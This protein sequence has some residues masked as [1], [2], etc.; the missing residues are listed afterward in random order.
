MVY[1]LA[2]ILVLLVLWSPLAVHALGL[3]EIDTHSALNQP[4]QAEIELLSVRPDE[5]DSI[6]AK[7]ASNATFEQAGVE[8]ISALSNLRFKVEQKPNGDHYIRVYTQELIKEPFLN[9]LIEVNW[10]AGHL[11]REY[12]VLL[13]PPVLT[14]ASPPRIQTPTA[15]V[16]PAPQ[17]DA[18]TGTAQSTPDVAPPSPVAPDTTTAPTPR[19]SNAELVRVNDTLWSVTQRLR[20]NAAIS[21]QQMMLALLKANPEAFVGNNVNNLKAGQRLHVP[22]TGEITLISQDDALRE[23]KR[24]HA[25]WAG[26]KAKPAVAAR[27]DESG[28][29][30]AAHIKLVAP[31]DANASASNSTA[32]DTV[33]SIDDLQKNLALANEAAESRRQE[34]DELR[35]RLAELEKQVESMQ[36]LITLKDENLANLQNN[37]ST[38]KP[39]EAATPP[40]PQEPAPQQAAPSTEPA[41]PAKPAPVAKSATDTPAPGA[42]QALWGDL[43]SNP[44]TQAIVVAAV[45]LLLALLWVVNR[46]RQMNAD[47]LTESDFYSMNLPLG[48]THAETAAAHTAIAAPETPHTVPHDQLAEVNVYLDFEQYPQAEALLKQLIAKDPHSDELKLRLLELYSLTKNKNAFGTQAEYLHTALGGQSSP[49]WDKAVSLGVQFYPQHPLFAAAA[50]VVRGAPAPV[51][52]VA[53]EPSQ[54]MDFTLDVPTAEEKQS[55]APSDGPLTFDF[56]IASSNQTEPDTTDSIDS[57]IEFSLT[58]FEQELESLTKASVTPEPSTTELPALDF[59]LDDLTPASPSATAKKREPDISFDFDFEKEAEALADSNM[60]TLEYEPDGDT[61]PFAVG[62]EIGTKIDLAR[63][64]IDMGDDDG[65]RSI[66]EEV[67][68][69]GN[70]AQKNEA[71]ELIRQLKS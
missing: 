68:V 31:N 27:T 1:T 3:G 25:L 56:D 21:P 7:L 23:I 39:D 10:S 55:P 29:A 62:D 40:A 50:G 13:D 6:V 20:P 60:T 19:E 44:I 17:P 18:V 32:Q 33:A 45:L 43:Q 30:D 49:L 59:A 58:E 9:F 46:R 47:A 41:Q 22:D 61:A 14:N 8:R 64:Y 69:E 63:A 71:R 53:E 67:V 16:T 4:L 5:I 34:N 70:D 28:P 26:A 65:A 15:K 57:P 48:D 42:L 37:V 24:Q 54:V 51:A 36:R 12:T 38:P 52:A 66:L 35:S 2:R 11:L